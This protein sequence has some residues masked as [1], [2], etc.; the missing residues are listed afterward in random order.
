MIIREIRAK[1]VLTRSKIYQYTVN[2]Y[3]GCSHSCAYCYA[4]FMQRFARH[5][6]PWGHFVD[7]KV[8]SVELLRKA[9]VKGRPGRVWISGVCDPY[10]SI[11]K[12]YKLTR[13]CLEVL[14]ENGW[15][16]T[17]QTKSPLV[18]R[19]LD[20]LKGKPGVEVG[21]S[22]AT[23]D[24]RFRKIFEPGAPPISERIK[25]L[26]ALHNEGITTFVMIAPLLPGAEVL[27]SLLAGKVDRILVDR[28]NYHY[29][30]R[31]YRQHHLEAA[32]TEA[33]FTSKSEQIAKACRGLGIEYRV[34]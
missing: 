8:N 25:A 3:V 4:R 27:P 22:I 31:V 2:P 15:P 28:I 20:L 12:R 34:I 9:V 32:K 1:T 5:A 24:E 13:G 16:V 18:L 7:V 14:L 11:E 17:I 30:D 21:M 29:A 33:F 23:A 26:G 6:E 10:Q 19:D